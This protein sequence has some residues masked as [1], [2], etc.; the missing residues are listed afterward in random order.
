MFML[1]ARTRQVADEKVILFTG[2]PTGLA[3]DYKYA[4]LV[5]TDT[6]NGAIFS[7][8][9]A[10]GCSF[11]CDDDDYATGVT[12]LVSG[13]SFPKRVA[14]S[15]GS[16]S[17]DDPHIYWTDPK[18]GRLYRATLKGKGKE[19]I[20]DGVDGIS[21]VACTE[22][23]VYFTASI[24]LYHIRVLVSV[25]KD[26]FQVPSSQSIYSVGFKGHDKKLVA[27]GICDTPDDISYSVDLKKM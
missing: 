8:N 22:D 6:H 11:D 25:R 2:Q 9:V 18:E 1:T 16:S 14:V 19:V 7:A 3:I 21:G 17:D 4:N 20:V 23:R 10:T 26:F 24:S 5:W 13:L 12:E 27:S 15:L